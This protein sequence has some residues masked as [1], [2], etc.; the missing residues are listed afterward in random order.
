MRQG[1]AATRGEIGLRFGWLRHSAEM[2][3]HSVRLLPAVCR[4]RDS[5]RRRAALGAI[6]SCCL[7]HTDT[8][9]VVNSGMEQFVRPGVGATPV[10]SLPTETAAFL[11]QA[12]PSPTCAGRAKMLVFT[13]P[14]LAR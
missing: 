5:D 3:V 10:N 12:T 9:A 6:T 8:R 13:L 1:V 14:D 4:S 2:V 11:H 7:R